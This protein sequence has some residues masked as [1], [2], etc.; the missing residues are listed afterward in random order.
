VIQFENEFLIHLSTFGDPDLMNNLDLS[1]ILRE[2]DF[3]E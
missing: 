1:E 2:N 3:M